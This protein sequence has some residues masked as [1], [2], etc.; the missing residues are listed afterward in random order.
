[1][2][3]GT[4]GT[5]DGLAF[6]WLL[7]TPEPSGALAKFET[8][9]GA[10]VRSRAE[11]QPRRWVRGAE[12]DGPAEPAAALAR[13]HR[14]LAWW[15]AAHPDGRPPVFVHCATADGLDGRAAAIV[16]SVRALAVPGGSVRVLEWTFTPG[17]DAGFPSDDVWRMLFDVGPEL[18][19]GGQS[20]EPAFAV[21]RLF[22]SQKRGNEPELWEDAYSVG[23]CGTVAAV[24]DGASDGIFCRDWAARLAARFTADR[25]DLRT[26]Q[27]VAAWVA[28]ARTDWRA[29]IHYPG[30]R[31]SQQN[32][33]NETGASA[34]LA[35]LEVGPPDP[36]G[37]R[38][39]RATAVGD[40]CVIHARGGEW[41][42]F[43]LTAADQFT[44]APA[45]LRT[46]LGVPVPSAGFATRHLPGGGLVPPRHGRRRR[47]ATRRR[48]DIPGLGGLRRDVRGGVAGGVR[49]TPGHRQDGERRLHAPRPPRRARP[50]GRTRR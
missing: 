39:W 25:P 17:A 31:W 1:M 33:V 20:G 40:A 36:S 16:R 3:T 30:L 12:A 11:G 22:W 26:R 21:E 47:E 35:G 5:P 44:S 13:A 50:L 32:K 7:P 6:E 24:C 28:A 4:G 38:P 8:L 2:S 27:A 45:L 48:R 42:S 37:D 14:V 15:A 19:S 49:R 18:E 34:T 29:A 10:E 41:L 43:P 46:K 9:A 23:P